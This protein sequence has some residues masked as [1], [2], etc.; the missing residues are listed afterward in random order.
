LEDKGY[1]GVLSFLIKKMEKNQIIKEFKWIDY[2]NPYNFA[3]VGN[4]CSMI[5]SEAPLSNF[6][7]V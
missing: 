4:S 5:I 6:K 7:T 2:L 1:R 3:T